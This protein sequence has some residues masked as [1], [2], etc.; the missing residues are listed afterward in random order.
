MSTAFWVFLACFVV[1]MAIGAPV[2][3]SM[4]CSSLAY[5]YLLGGISDITIIQKMFTSLD[6][7]VLLAIPMFMLAGN[8]MNAGGVT[9][10]IFNFC[11]ALVGHFR[12]GLAYVNVLASFIFSGMSGS[13]LADVGGLGQIE[14]KAMK[15]EGYDDHMILGVT[16]ASST[17]GP[18]VPPSIPLVLFGSAANVSVGALFLG[19][20]VPGVLIAL[21][22][23][24]VIYFVAKKKNYPSRKRST[25]KEIL[26]TVRSGFFINFKIIKKGS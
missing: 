15:D 16:A 4:L 14:I 26:R 7:F 12:G 19:G 11:R 21:V 3:L 17:M 13:A 8:I 22:L 10:R 2:F 9:D 24:T 18:I 25:L 5:C 23:C 1:L 20:V 6:N